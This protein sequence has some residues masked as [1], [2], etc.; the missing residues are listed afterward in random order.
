LRVNILRIISK[1]RDFRFIGGSSVGLF[2]ISGIIWLLFIADKLR[3]V[4]QWQYRARSS[5]LHARTDGWQ[6]YGCLWR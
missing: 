1:C 3:N 5:F 6:T 2:F 4:C